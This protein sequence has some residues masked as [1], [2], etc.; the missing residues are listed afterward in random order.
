[1][2][3]SPEKVG[4]WVMRRR[5]QDRQ[6]QRVESARKIQHYSRMW[7][8]R[9]QVTATNA[10]VRAAFASNRLAVDHLQVSLGLLEDA[11]RDLLA[12]LR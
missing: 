7:L 4:N 1:M 6:K 9:R 10:A 2:N 3:C 12:A 8:A 5:F 11:G